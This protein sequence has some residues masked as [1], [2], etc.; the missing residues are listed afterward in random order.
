L[1]GFLSEINV[2]HIE[3]CILE[4]VKFPAPLQSKETIKFVEKILEFSSYFDRLKQARKID[5]K[6]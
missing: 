3:K 2:K 1:I 6:N 5:F 4:I